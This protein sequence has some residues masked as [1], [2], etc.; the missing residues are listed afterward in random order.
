MAAAAAPRSAVMLDRNHAA[1]HALRLGLATAVAL[2]PSLAF[3]Q[4]DASE[5]EATERAGP[6]HRSMPTWTC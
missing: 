6:R 5:L 2:L 4:S 3:P 1:R